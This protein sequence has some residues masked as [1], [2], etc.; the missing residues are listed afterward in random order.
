[1][2]L[3]DLFPTL[4][5]AARV[6]LQTNAVMDG[7]ELSALLKDPAAK[8]DRDAL[9]FHFPHYYHAPPTTPVS[10]MR[11]GDWKL[12]EYFEDG[13]LELYNLRDDPGEQ[14]QVA[15]RLPTKAAELRQRLETWR[16]S[17]QAAL[18]QPNPAYQPS[19][20]SAR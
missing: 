11:A 17:V 15:E 12:L 9:F 13:H 8:L 5:A 2:V 1:V 16:R 18:P 4:L 7:V 19:P 20:A 6:A 3:T 14:T 10:A